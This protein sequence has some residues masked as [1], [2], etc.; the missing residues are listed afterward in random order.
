MNHL[1]LL[2]YFI[3]LMV[4]VAASVTIQ[5][6]YKTYKHS[7][8][9]FLLRYIIFLNL[10]LLIYLI[11]T[12]LHLNSTAAQ[13]KDPNSAFYAVLYILAI[14]VW[15]GC[16]HSFIQLVFR[17]KGGNDPRK[18][19][20]IFQVG[21]ILVG[22]LCVIGVTTYVHT[23][24]NQWNMGIYLGLMLVAM[25]V[26]FS[27]MISLMLYRDPDENI[28][29]R[30]SIRIYGWLH[31]A[32]YILFFS[33]PFLQGT[34]KICILSG[35]LISVNLIPQIWLRYFFLRYTIQFSAHE[36]SPPLDV[37][38]QKYLISHREREIMEL[39]MEGKSNQEIEKTLFISYN[40]VKNHIYN[41][42]QKLGVKSRSQMIHFVLE[43]LKLEKGSDETSS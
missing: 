39:I 16:I 32:A 12:Y 1:M 43:A 13:F 31:L 15:V 4:G 40:T 18:I 26:F 5:H 23:G 21:L 42:Y 41:I 34:L 9:R 30:K 27:G 8:L 14:G 36:M 2:G 17:L 29:R 6:F 33:P 38:T 7:F 24:S 10:A 20:R 22:F 25:L 35:A 37:V 28:G 11:S 3:A 19:N